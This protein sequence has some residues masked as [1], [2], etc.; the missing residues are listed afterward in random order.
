MLRITGPTLAR[1]TNHPPPVRQRHN[2]IGDLIRNRIVEHMA[3]SR[4]QSEV[5][6]RNW[7]VEPLGMALVAHV[8]I[9][10]PAMI[11]TGM[12]RS[13][14]RSDIPTTAGPVATASGDS[15]RICHG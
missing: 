4:S 1:P 6:I 3:C 7:L 8:P 2:G 10:E 11:V 5:T 9:L 14:T 12:I 15:A 13:R